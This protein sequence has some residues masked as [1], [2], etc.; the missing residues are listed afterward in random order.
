MLE[1]LLIIIVLIL[2]YKLIQKESRKKKAKTKPAPTK[3]TPSTKAEKEYEYKKKGYFF[4]KAESAFYRNL[5]KATEEHYIVLSKVRIADLIE[6]NYTPYTET[7]GKA[8]NKISRKHVDFVLID[9]QKLMISAAI[10]LDDSS[11]EKANRKKSDHIKNMAFKNAGLALFR[12]KKG[13]DFNSDKLKEVFG[14]TKLE[15]ES[16]SFNPVNNKVSDVGTL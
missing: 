2:A 7:Y 9:K 13:T 3:N 5:V 1:A 8:F 11:H 10:E 12:I 14:I 6:P 16:T 15:N 4:T